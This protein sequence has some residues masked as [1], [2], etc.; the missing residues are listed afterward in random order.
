MFGMYSQTLPTASEI[1]QRNTTIGKT[2]RTRVVKGEGGHAHG[3]PMALH[4]GESFWGETE[5]GA[6]YSSLS[7]VVCGQGR[8]PFTRQGGGGGGGLYAW[9]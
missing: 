8:S 2:T 3:N 5:E 9:R 4:P 7:W 1:R 6:D